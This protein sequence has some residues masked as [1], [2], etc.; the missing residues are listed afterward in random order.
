MLILIRSRRY[1]FYKDDKGNLYELENYNN[2]VQLDALSPQVSGYKLKAGDY[3]S[4]TVAPNIKMADK[5]I[6]SDNE[7]SN[8]GF[9]LFS[10][11]NSNSNG[12]F[13]SFYQT[14]LMYYTATVGRHS[15][16]FKLEGGEKDQPYT[17]FYQLNNTKRDT[18]T[19]LFVADS[20]V[21][22]VYGKR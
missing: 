1:G 5:S 4:K 10:T 15:T 13:F 20:R 19:L 2:D 11:S 6:I 3:S 14:W 16:S 9:S 8:G 21:W 17:T 12:I 7:I 22:M 18:D